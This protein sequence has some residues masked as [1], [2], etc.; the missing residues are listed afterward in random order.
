M[1]PMIIC[2]WELQEQKHKR[3]HDS[4]LGVGLMLHLLSLAMSS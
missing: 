4:L 2:P 3:K 1:N